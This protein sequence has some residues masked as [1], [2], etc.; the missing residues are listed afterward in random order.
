VNVTIQLAE[1]STGIPELDKH[2][3]GALFLDTAKFPTATFVSD[4]IIKKGKDTAQVVGTLNL[5]GI[6]KPLTL[7]VKFNK[8]GMN[9]VTNKPAVGFSATAKLKRSDFNISGFLPNVGDEVTL[10][11]EAEAYKGKKD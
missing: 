10:N 1:V 11:I 7:N 5:H 9:P 3:K 6:S 8:A 2:L 4:K